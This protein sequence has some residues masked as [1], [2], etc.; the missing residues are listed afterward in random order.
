MNDLRSPCAQFTL[1]F[2]LPVSAAKAR[3]PNPDYRPLIVACRPFV[4]AVYRPSGPRDLAQRGSAQRWRGPCD[5]SPSA[6]RIPN[7]ARSTT[8]TWSSLPWVGEARPS[9]VESPSM[10]SRA[11]LAEPAPGDPILLRGLPVTANCWATQ[12]CPKRHP[13]PGRCSAAYLSVAGL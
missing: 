10:P 2:M 8:Q 13:R 3:P 6:R 7:L 4:P 12:R 1:R 11:P 9:P 5:Q